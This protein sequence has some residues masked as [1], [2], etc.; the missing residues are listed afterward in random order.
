[1]YIYM[2]VYIHVIK[3]QHVLTCKGA[4]SKGLIDVQGK[5]WASSCC[6]A[7]R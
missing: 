1:M 7:L 2:Y 3:T 5:Q 4:R 6:N